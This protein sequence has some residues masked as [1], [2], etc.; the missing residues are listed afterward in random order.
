[1][2]RQI[3]RRTFIRNT[4]LGMASATG[5][6]GWLSCS[7]RKSHPVF[8]ARVSNYQQDLSSTLKASLKELRITDNFVR[9]KRVLLKPNLVETIMGKAY[10]NTHPMV[11]RAAIETFFDLGAASVRVAEG[12]GHNRDSLLVLKESGYFEVLKEDNI[13]FIDLNYD[14]VFMIDNT[15][16]TTGLRRLV[17]P[18]SL[19]NTDILVSMPKMKTHHWAGA[20]LT[21]K[22]LFGIMPGSVYG[23]PKNVL[24]RVGIQKSIVDINYNMPA[25]IS[26]VDGIVGMEGDGP[27]MGT[28]VQSNVLIIGT[29]SPAVDATATRIMGIDPFKIPY[30]KNADNLIGPISETRIE[31]RGES[32]KNCRINFKLI[33]KIEAHQNICLE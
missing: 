5:L 9:D 20:T 8:I 4:T 26:I 33:P 17:F 23:W 27:I 25:Q 31:Q 22:N 11:I 6:S 7:T 24:H 2:K 14:D 18:K 3:S 16:N 32:I 13:D 30:L 19:L 10:I 15:L 28:P 1:M 29:N 12:P 21:M